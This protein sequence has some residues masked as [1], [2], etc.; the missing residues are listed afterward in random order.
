MRIR[1]FHSWSADFKG[2]WHASVTVSGPFAWT[3]MEQMI[4]EK[5][6][7]KT[8]ELKAYFCI[9]TY[10]FGYSTYCSLGHIWPHIKWDLTQQHFTNRKSFWTS[11]VTTSTLERTEIT[12]NG[13]T[14][15]EMTCKPNTVSLFR[16]LNSFFFYID[17]HLLYREKN[18]THSKESFDTW[19]K[20]WQHPKFTS[21]IH[22]HNHITPFSRNL[23]YI[24]QINNMWK[25]GYRTWP[26]K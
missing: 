25:K 8:I 1:E 6:R 23:T 12:G 2:I 11:A 14:N 5:K 24:Q 18:A 10:I 16:G 7:I 15:T 20:K 4:G 17:I 19:C 13:E 9:F 26:G 22:K 3:K 21:D